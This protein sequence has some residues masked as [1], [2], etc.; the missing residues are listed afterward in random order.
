MSLVTRVFKSFLEYGS[1]FLLLFLWFLSLEYLLTLDI[2]HCPY[3]LIVF[4]IFLRTFLH[5]GLFVITHDAIHGSAV[6][7]NSDLNNFL[8]KLAISLYAFLPYKMLKNQHFLH[9]KCPTSSQDPDYHEG[10]K[11]NLCNWYLSF[12]RTYLK[13]RRVLIVLSGVS[14]ISLLALKFLSVEPINLLLFWLIPLILSSMQLFYF[15][16]YLPHKRT[17]TRDKTKHCATSTQFST[18]WSFLTCYHFGYHLEHHT[19]PSLP[20]HALPNRRRTSLAQQAE[21]GS[22]AGQ[23]AK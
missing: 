19:Y 10:I 9:H 2:S 3:V 12:M 20:W 21:L 1:S 7:Q 17:V 22:K 4:A 5:T 13:G 16:T 23:L 6:P 14:I 18:F 11:S 15:G 8:G